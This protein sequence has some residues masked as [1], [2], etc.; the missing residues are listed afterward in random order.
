MSEGSADLH[1][2]TT[3]SDGTFTPGELVQEAARRGLTAIA[4][5]DH[6][7][8]DGVAEASAMGAEVGVWVVPGV[9]IST[10]LDNGEIHVLGYFIN[11]RDGRLSDLLSSQRESRHARVVQMI[12]KLADLGVHISLED[13][14]ACAGDGA[15][16]RPHVAAALIRAGYVT[17]WDDAFARYIG[18]HAS[19][20]VRRSKLTPTDAV[21]EISAAGG[22]S[23]LAHP[24][25]SNRDDMIP[26][27]VRAGLAGIEA[28]YPDHSREQR[29][30]YE[31]V[32]AQYGLIVTGG[33]DCHGPRSKSGVVL[34]K[35]TVDQSVVASLAA[36]SRAV[37]Q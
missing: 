36:R 22:V 9:E 10:D 33:S 7:S 21:T 30:H 26:Q 5:T 27:L 37:L 20:Y 11:T 25:L 2:H 3:A 32:A 16:G 34:G 12:G 13:V 23:V 8:V 6:D 19:A 35:A 1:C 24:G 15:L 14:M 17:S 31:R 4:V 18:R 28:I 29:L